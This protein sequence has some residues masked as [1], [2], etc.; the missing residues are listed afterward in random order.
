[1]EHLDISVVVYVQANSI[2]GL[3]HCVRVRALV[4]SLPFEYR[5]A[6]NTDDEL[7]AHFFPDAELHS[8]SEILSVLAA[9]CRSELVILITDCPNVPDEIW[10]FKHPKLIKV[11]I[12][13][14]GSA[15]LN[16]DI[17]IN[18]SGYPGYHR[19]PSMQN[20]ISLLGLKYSPLRA[21]FGCAA[22]FILRGK[23]LGVMA[24]SSQIASDWIR[25][26]LD[27]DFSHLCSPGY[28]R[29]VMSP[30]AQ[31]FAEIQRYGDEKG[32]SVRRGLST[33][34]ILDFFRECRLCVMT[35]GT[36]L[37]EA[38]C[39]KVPVVA[40]PIQQNMKKECAYYET[41]GLLVNVVD[42]MNEAALA[43][44]IRN[45]WADSETLEGMSA[46]ARAQV[47]G[48]GLMRASRVIT[49]VVQKCAGGTNKSMAMV[50]THKE[51]YD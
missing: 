7:A 4:D 45:I 5:L 9:R 27:M 18:C 48:Q 41:E 40:Y 32:I 22:R 34:E 15:V 20:G 38:F 17:L 30:S 43:G 6:L 46:R 36:S 47:D 39:C 28:I 25:A 11:A 51:I 50:S 29:V 12:D 16:C 3:G 21:E 13:D 10:N 37:Y 8:R 24:G 31:H 23:Y 19:Y 49:T 35:A 2:I 42:G 26:V 14:I 44:A 33:A 1:M